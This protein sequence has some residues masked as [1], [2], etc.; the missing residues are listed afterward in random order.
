[1]S[2]RSRTRPN[3]RAPWQDQDDNNQAAYGRFFI[4]G[5]EPIMS[6]TLSTDELVAV[7]GYK[8]AAKQQCSLLKSTT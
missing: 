3:K 8:D 2:R 6:I 1:M 7:T 5:K 4:S